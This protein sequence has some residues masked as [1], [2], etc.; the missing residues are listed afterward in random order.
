MIIYPS[1][2]VAS[3]AA[4][5]VPL[6]QARIGYQTWLRDLDATAVTV[7]TEDADAPADAPLRPDTGEYWAPTA[8]PATW[9]VNLGAARSIDYVGIAGHTIGS[10]G[11][12]VLV[13]WS[14]GSVAGSP[15]E[16]VWTTFAAEVNPGDDA[17]LLF[18]D[19]AVTA[20]YLRI[21]LSA[22]GATMPRVASI[23]A[24][25][26]LAMTRPIYGG[27]VP[28]TLSRVTALHN[29]LSNGGQFLGQAF[30]RL[31]VQTAAS[32]KHL[33]PT[34]VRTDFDLFVKAARRFPYFFAW[35]PAD[36]PLEVGYVWSDK[37]IAPSNMGQREF[38][39]VSWKMS[40]IGNE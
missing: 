36:W 32:F 23:Y 38:M 21:T 1:A 26:A 18:L 20:S 4:A 15:A 19:D 35:R 22:G 17:P 9:E 16:L 7:S 24:G 3:A 10:C 14:D 29:T 13:E 40:G 8:L 31:G 37:D 2:F 33:D 5:G 11:C 39:Q 34:W 6:T 27:H 30:K 25:V 28:I 12:A